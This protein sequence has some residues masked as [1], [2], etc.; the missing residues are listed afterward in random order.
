MD[1]RLRK[2]LKRIVMMYWSDE[3]DHWE[4]LD[5]GNYLHE[6]HIFTSLNNVRNYL[7]R[8]EKEENDKQESK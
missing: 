8:L 4:E 5:K 6:D 2:D 1:N 7:I 3:K